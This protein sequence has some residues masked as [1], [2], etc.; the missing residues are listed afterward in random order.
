[1]IYIVAFLI[2]T[3][4]RVTKIMISNNYALHETRPILGR[5]MS[6]THV[7]NFGAA[8]SI[9]QGKRLFIIA[10]TV[11][12]IGII[13]YIYYK[14]IPRTTFSTVIVGMI[15]GG[16]L[17]NFYDRIRFAYV[18][19]FIDFHF[20]PVFNIADSVVVIGSFLLAWQ[21]WQIPEAGK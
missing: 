18:I 10:S 6:F 21:L 7:R 20:F 17:G 16:A 11:V 2:W 5:L 4:D 15:L 13:I 19:D 1:M 9:L 3:A 8:F 12:L 14:I